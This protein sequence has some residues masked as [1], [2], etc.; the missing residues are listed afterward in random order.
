VWEWE[1]SAHWTKA[2]ILLKGRRPLKQRSAILRFAS[3]HLAG[4]C[5]SGGILEI[6]G[7]R[8][9]E[10]EHRTGWTPGRRCVRLK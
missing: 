5:G 2:F 1:G 4:C 8:V 7:V 6:L 3:E 10:I 9:V